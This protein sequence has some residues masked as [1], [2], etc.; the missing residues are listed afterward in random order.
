MLARKLKSLKAKLEVAF[1]ITLIMLLTKA[2]KIS[3]NHARQFTH[4]P[5]KLFPAL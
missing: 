4:F 2:F 1:F 3:T 5:D